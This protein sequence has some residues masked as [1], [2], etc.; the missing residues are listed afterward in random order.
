MSGVNA[1]MGVARVCVR[2]HAFALR[3]LITLCSLNNIVQ[4]KHIAMMRRSENH[5]ILV[6]RFIME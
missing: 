5:H 4:Y 1:Q 2:L 6:F 3:K